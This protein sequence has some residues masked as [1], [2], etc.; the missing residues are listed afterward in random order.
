MSPEQAA[1]EKVDARSDIFSASAVAYLIV[2]GR[3]PF[4]GPDLRHTLDALLTRDPLPMNDTEAPAILRAVL[5]KGLAKNPAQR[6]QT[7]A[8]MLRDLEAVRP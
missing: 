3:A 4:T 1:G 2:T 8:E 5:N 7:A 6:Y